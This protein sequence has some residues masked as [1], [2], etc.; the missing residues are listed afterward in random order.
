MKFI[1]LVALLIACSSHA[2]ESSFKN[3]EFK[4]ICENSIGSS[5]MLEN[6]KL[7]TAKHV[8]TNVGR[9]VA[10]DH[11]SKQYA[12][13][14][15]KSSTDTD[16]ALMKFV[17]IKPNAAGVKLADNMPTQ[18]NQVFLISHPTGLDMQ[19]CTTGMYQ[20]SYDGT[21]DIMTAN[22]YHGS[23]GGPVFFMENGQPRLAGIAKSLAVDGG[24]SVSYLTVFTNLKSIKKFVE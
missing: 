5:V 1:P 12:I 13:E 2:Q 19:V 22:A 23:S 17:G 3:D 16:L 7:L 15:S 11:E 4:I 14:I 9:C 21:I 10:Q 24:V 18:Y 8:V 6:G 20:G